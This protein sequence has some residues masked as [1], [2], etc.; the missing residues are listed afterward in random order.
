MRFMF[1]MLPVSISGLR[2]TAALAVARARD[3]ASCPRRR[4]RAVACGRRGARRGRGS[5]RAAGLL[6]QLVQRQV[7]QV[8]VAGPS[9]ITLLTFE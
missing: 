1:V 5:R 6:H 8:G 2:V 4:C 7:Q 9:I 3:P